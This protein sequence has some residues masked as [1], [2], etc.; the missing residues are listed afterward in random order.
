MSAAYVKV[1]MEQ[2]PL[3]KPEGQ[4]SLPRKTSKHVE[5]RADKLH[6]PS[7]LCEPQERGT[8]CR[9]PAPVFTAS[10]VH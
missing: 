10:P 3:G 7:D 1:G 9:A 4:T 2:G 8:L 5:W 6:S